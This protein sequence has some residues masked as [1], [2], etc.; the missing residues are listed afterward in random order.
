MAD[1]GKKYPGQLDRYTALREAREK[2][3]A[4]GKTVDPFLVLAE[5]L[6][7]ASYILDGIRYNTRNRG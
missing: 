5:E 2:T 6:A 7:G 3:E 1:N 4:D